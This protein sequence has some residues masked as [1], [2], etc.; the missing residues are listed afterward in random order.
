VRL[1]LSKSGL[2]VS[3]GIRG[4]R[5]GLDSKGRKYASA[6]LPG[7]GI[8]SRHYFSGSRHTEPPPILAPS[9]T[10]QPARISPAV[11]LLIAA[12]VTAIG[13]VGMMA[14]V[15]YLLQ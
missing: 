5:V 15:A 14:A 10:K 9:Q 4:L 12:G 13:L 1:N 3:A 11:G 6:G 2:G 8:S 7:T